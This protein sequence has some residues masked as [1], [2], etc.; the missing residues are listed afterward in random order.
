MIAG[1]GANAAWFNARIDSAPDGGT[2]LT[3]TVGLPGFQIGA[4]GALVANV[5][6]IGIGA[7]CFVIGLVIT[8]SGHFNLGT[9][10]AIG[11]PVLVVLAILASRGGKPGPGAEARE[12]PIPGLL[13]KINGVLG[14]TAEFPG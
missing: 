12:E 2:T 13:Q 6:W 5:L 7:F 9:G 8:A 11:L 14:S 3:G 4:V 1:V 10:V